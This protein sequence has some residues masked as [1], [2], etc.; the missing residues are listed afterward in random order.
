MKTSLV[1]LLPNLEDF[2]GVSKIKRVFYCD[3]NFIPLNIVI[4]LNQYE[5][6]LNTVLNGIKLL[7]E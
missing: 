1:L 5:Y 3:C 7:S 2:N 4:I 6:E